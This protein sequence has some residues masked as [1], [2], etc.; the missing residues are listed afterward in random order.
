MFKIYFRNIL[1]AVFTHKILFR[2]GYTQKCEVEYKCVY[3]IRIPLILE[4]LRVHQK[5]LVC[6]YSKFKQ[7]FRIFYKY[8][9][10]V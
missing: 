6:F 4:T 1:I 9:I 3:V 2:P 10:W 8:F 7:I 5:H